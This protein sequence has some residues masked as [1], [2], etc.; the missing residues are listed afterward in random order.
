MSLNNQLIAQLKNK[1]QLK[2]PWHALRSIQQNNKKNMY[3]IN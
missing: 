1:W 2:D 3:H